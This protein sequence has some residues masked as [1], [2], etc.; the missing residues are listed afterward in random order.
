MKTMWKFILDNLI[1]IHSGAWYSKILSLGKL[2]VI[3]AFG[4]SI[5]EALSGWYLENWVFMSFVT[6]A[7][8]IDHAFGSYVHWLIKNDFSWR[9]NLHG[10]LNKGFSVVAVYVLLEMMHQI[11]DDV[12][13]VAIYFKVVLQL[14]VFL[15]PAGSAFA[16]I[17]IMTK[18]RFPPSGWMDRLRKFNEDVKLNHFKTENDEKNNDYPDMPYHDGLPNERESSIEGEGENRN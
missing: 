4:I 10:F 11:V 6:F 5:T 15:Y 1:T 14:I 16:N 7:I 18:G 12:D 13:F 17:A 3:P 8:V 2:S 9:K